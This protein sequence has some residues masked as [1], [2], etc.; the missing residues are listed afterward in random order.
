MDQLKEYFAVAV[1]YG[2]WIGS[3]VVL[4]CSVAFWYLSTSKLATE[5]EKNRSAIKS[6]ISMVSSIQSE[7]STHPNEKSHAEMKKLIE[8]RQNQVLQSW[9]TLFDRQREILVWPEEELTKKFV[10]QFRNKIPIEYYVEHPTPEADELTT[11]MRATYAKHI[12][13]ELPDLA[14][15]AGAEWIAEFAADN[16]DG[17]MGMGMGMSRSRLDPSSREDM[18]LG[19]KQGPLVV[20]SEQS[21]SNL[22]ND[23]F[24]WR[25]TGLP[26]TLDIYYSQENLWVLHQLLEIIGAVNGPAK[27]PYQAKIHEINSI[28]IGSSVVFGAGQ[29]VPPGSH[30]K[31]GG[32]GMGM[33]MDDMGMDDMGMDFGMGMGMGGMEEMSPDPA[34]FRYVSEG[35][36]KIA[37]I[38]LRSALKDIKPQNVSLAIAKR[39]PVMMSL[40]M[41]Q[42]AVPELLAACG[43]AKLM[44]KVRQTRIMPKGKTLSTGGSMSGGMGMGMEDMGME[45]DMGMGGMGGMGMGGM[46]GRGMGGY[47]PGSSQPVDE[48]PL[49]MQVEIYGLIYIY[50]PPDLE[51]LAIEQITEE[52]VDQA[53]QDL[54]GEA[55]EKHEAPVQPPAPITPPGAGAGGDDV[56]PMPGATTPP[57]PNPEGAPAAPA[58]APGAP[59]TSLPG[60]DPVPTG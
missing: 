42:R 49:D 48:F 24:P 18:I 22:L 1:K 3:A 44:V 50:N 27:Q 45:E 32:M 53:V 51:K 31:S 25:A 16:R 40:K 33:G 60:T 38:D 56:L 7:L 29:I 13:E 59:V 20:W 28:K 41:N 12:K 15:I 58:P 23:L 4:L 55:I 10:D 47:T 21:Q 9:E 8:D 36:E 2:F 19:V 11:S 5:A 52:T 57:G 54:S 43:S 34:E 6:S 26:K 46:G 17:G 35:L 14:A 30:S 39:L 37:A